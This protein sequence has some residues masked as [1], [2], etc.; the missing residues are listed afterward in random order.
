[1]SNDPNKIAAVEKAIAEKY[2]VATVQH[3]AKDWNPEKEQ[4]YIDKLVA[5]GRFTEIEAK[6]ILQKMGKEGQIYEVTKGKY[7]R[8]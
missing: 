6:Q 2:G 1:M 7:L 4:E 3:P 8:S 5:T